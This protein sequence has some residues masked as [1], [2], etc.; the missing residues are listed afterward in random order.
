[1]ASSQ[2]LAWAGQKLARRLPAGRGPRAEFCTPLGGAV[3]VGSRMPGAK[4]PHCLFLPKHPGRGQHGE[5]T[6]A[7]RGQ[8]SMPAGAAHLECRDL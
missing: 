8:A 3:T 4:D 2:L 6:L 1:M 7:S 5:P